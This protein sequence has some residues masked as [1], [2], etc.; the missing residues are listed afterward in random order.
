MDKVAVLQ[1]VSCW[2]SEDQL[3]LLETLWDRI[4]DSGW[5]PDLTDAQKAEFD[6][7]LAAHEANPNDVVTW[8]EIEEYVRRPR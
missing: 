6:R 3:D 8:D 1:E 2:S 5:Q 4:T 7:R